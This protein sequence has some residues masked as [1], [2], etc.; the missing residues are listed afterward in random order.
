MR[1]M[2]GGEASRGRSRRGEGK[3]LDEDVGGE[4]KREEKRK[5]G[6]GGK[7]KRPTEKKGGEGMRDKRGEG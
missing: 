3:Q 6:G 4:V 1:S 2:R 5:K 7:G